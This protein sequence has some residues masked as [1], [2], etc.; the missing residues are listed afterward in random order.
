VPLGRPAEKA[1]TRYL[2]HPRRQRFANAPVVFLTDE[3]EPLGLNA[4]QLALQRHGKAAG[5]HA[6]AHK[7]RHSSAIQ[8]LRSGGRVETLRTM[9]GHT[10]LEMTLHYARQA[11]VDLTTAHEA[12][13]PAR[14]LKVRV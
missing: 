10:T 2:N 3:G 6:N 8:Y 9:L 11:G 7:F 12:F 5:I 1:L 14:S 4:L 13:D